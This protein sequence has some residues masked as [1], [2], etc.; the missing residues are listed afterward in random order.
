MGIR[1]NITYNCIHLYYDERPNNVNCDNMCN[2]PFNITIIPSP[3][4]SVCIQFWPIRRKFKTH[5]IHGKHVFR[6]LDVHWY[7]YNGFAKTF[8]GRVLN[9][10]WKKKI[11]NNT[12]ITI[13]LLHCTNHNCNHCYELKRTKLVCNTLQFLMP[14]TLNQY[15]EYV[16]NDNSRVKPNRF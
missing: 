16:Y 6:L 4:P 3:A 10:F 11:V 14:L 8:N 5:V 12:L 7:I 9:V 2:F 1:I 13:Q 15:T